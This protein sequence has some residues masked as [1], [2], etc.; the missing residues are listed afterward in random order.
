MGAPLLDEII[1]EIILSVVMHQLHVK[2]QG[3][4]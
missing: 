4:F 3:R 2:H 1:E